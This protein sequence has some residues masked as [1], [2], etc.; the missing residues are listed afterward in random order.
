MVWQLPK[1]ECKLAIVNAM[2]TCT[3][4]RDERKSRG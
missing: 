1:L 3:T 2:H 4:E